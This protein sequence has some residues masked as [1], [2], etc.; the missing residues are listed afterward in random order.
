M[1]TR[2]TRFKLEI[3]YSLQLGA[4]ISAISYLSWLSE[5]QIMIKQLNK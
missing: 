3:I 4:P 5:T 1:D 2:L